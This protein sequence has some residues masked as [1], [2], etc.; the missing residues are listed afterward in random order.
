MMRRLFQY[1]FCL[2]CISVLTAC[3][4]ENKEVIH[5][6]EYAEHLL[7][8]DPDSAL[9]YLNAQKRTETFKDSRS[10]MK[11]DLIAALAQNSADI[12]FTSDTTVLRVVDYFNKHGNRNEQMRAYYAMGCVY[13]DLHDAP[14]AISYYNIAANKADTTHADCDYRTLSRIYGQ[15]AAVFHEQRSP[16]LELKYEQKAIDAAWHSK[17][18]L[19]A[20][21]FYSGLAEPYDLLRNDD[22]VLVISENSYHKLRK[23]GYM[24]LAV[25]SL[26]RAIQ[27]HLLREEYDK[28]IEQIQLYEK[29]S[30]LIDLDGNISKGNEFFYSY[31]GRY[32]EGTNN[33]DSAEI[34]F[35]KLL[36]YVDQNNCALAAY[37]GLSSIYRKR[38]NN[39]EALKYASL[40]ANVQSRAAMKLATEETV[41]AQAM[42][43]Y[44]Q[45]LDQ[46]ENVENSKTILKYSLISGLVIAILVFFELTK[47]NKKIKE[48]LQS[49]ENKHKKYKDKKDQE[50]I[51]LQ[52]TISNFEDISSKVESWNNELE[53]KR[54]NLISILHSK[55]SK[56]Q[57]ATTTELNELIEYSQAYYKSYVDALAEG[58][59]SATETNMCILLKNGFDSAEIIVLM[60]LSRQRS[61]NLRHNINLKLFKEDSTKNVEYN[62]KKL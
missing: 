60:N 46:K 35:N 34:Y 30:G 6:L 22:S 24:D 17:D 16:E 23:L 9:H 18:T 26:N 3:S 5:I 37:R 62:L 56:G 49:F 54:I 25:Q 39:K 19:A 31:R 4:K 48:E 47:R 10:I 11:V 41:K 28:V 38:G 42:Y 53:E 1:F 43:D 50:I 36:P 7:Y 55:A 61:S 2:L 32:Y 52:K 13:R 40:Y 15:M 45:I 59:L 51:E 14:L 20:V 12:P 21:L 29:Y 58:K 57:A 27:I 33:L 8:S 44:Q